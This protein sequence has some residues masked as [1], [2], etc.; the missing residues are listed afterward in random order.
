M[1]I[2]SNS[3]TID[4]F[5][6]WV[7]WHLEKIVIKAKKSVT[8]VKSNA[9]AAGAYQSS[10]TIILVFE[11]V[12]E[13]FDQGLDVALGEL[14]RSCRI[15]DLDQKLLRTTTEER[16]NKFVTEMKA[17]TG[18]ESLRNFAGGM[19]SNIDE[20]L[21]NFD[22]KL[23]FALRQFD[24]GL[25]DPL[26]PEAPLSM[27]NS[28]NIGVMAG[29]AVQQGSQGAT[30]NLSIEINIEDT[31]TAL[32]KFEDAIRAEAVPVDELAEITAD[33]DTIKTQ[34]AYSGVSGSSI[35]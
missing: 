27:T 21:N 3:P 14:K 11:A 33:L 32:T 35:Q 4:D 6:A 16:L 2:A 8:Q 20:C 29:G 28:I 26:E 7:D 12:H 5:T 13:E 30:Q 25:L 9:A 24:V 1:T 18:A 34:L 23:V 10:R 15:T 19:N 17:A 22:K 31:K